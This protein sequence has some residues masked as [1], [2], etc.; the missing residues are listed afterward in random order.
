MRPIPIGEAIAAQRPEW[1]VFIVTRR[2][3]GF[4]DVMPAGWV[5]RA[6]GS[7]AMFAVSVGHLRYTNELVRHAGEFVL[8]F[9][10][11]GQEG[12]VAIC[13]SHSGRDLDKVERCAL[14]LQRGEA[15]ETP[16][17][18]DAFLN[19]E[20][21]LVTATETGDHTVFVG[22]VMAAH[23]GEVAGP[24]VNFGDGVYA[25]AERKRGS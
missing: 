12:V 23:R 11:A 3:D 7:P 25:L 20:C 9:P 14:R 17:L 10:A 6:S 21:R 19:F 1:I 8:A 15:I 24:L 5:M 13:G 22:E 4:V 18:A 16:L 2:G